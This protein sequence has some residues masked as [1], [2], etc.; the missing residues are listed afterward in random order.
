VHD[1]LT[2]VIYNPAAGRGR[3]KKQID[4]TRNRLAPQAEL[5]PTEGPG[6]AVEVARTAVE[7]GFRR[8]IAAGGDGTVHEVANGILNANEPGAVLS[9][10][11]LGSMNDYA[12][13]LG[14]L[15]WWQHHEP[16]PLDRIQVD[17]GMATAGERTMWFVNSAGVGFNGMVTI[18][19]RKIRWLRGIPL[20]AWALLKS[21]AKHYSAPRLTII[22]GE[23]HTEGPVLAFGIY[24]GQREGGFPIGKDVALDD[25]LFDTFHVTDI[26]RW[27][28]VRYL[29]GLITG[30]LPQNHPKLRRGRSANIEIRGSIP[31]C[32][33]LDGELLCRPEDGQYQLQF[34]LV[35]NR[36]MVECYRPGL[37]GV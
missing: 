22:D 23:T 20:Y 15:K 19:S 14:M 28:L 35:P 31:L 25:G 13:T 6:H 37:Y 9:I 27:E 32:C 30:N 11:P 8:I 21:I 1:E 3:A 34:Q 18:E 26:W 5:M 17:V 33:H 4:K 2:C 36:L 16:P 29:P 10:W 24:L 12:F 7:R